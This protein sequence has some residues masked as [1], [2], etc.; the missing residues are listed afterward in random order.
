M[1][2]STPGQPYLNLTIAALLIMGLAGIV[3]HST[4]A[5]SSGRAAV[6]TAGPSPEANLPAT[7]G[8]QSVG[9]G[10]NEARD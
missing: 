4:P 6:A 7:P 9:D 5:A 8:N 3:I 2:S 10:A 1:N